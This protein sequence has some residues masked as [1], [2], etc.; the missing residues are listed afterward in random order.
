MLFKVFAVDPSINKMGWAV[1]NSREEIINAGILN[2]TG[3]GS[4]NARIKMIIHEIHKLLVANEIK[5][6]DYFVVEACAQIVNPRS[7]LILE[8]VRSAIETVAIIHGVKVPGRVNPR[9]IHVRMLG[10]E[11]PEK[12]SKIKQITRQFVSSNYLDFFRVNNIDVDRKNQDIFDAILIGMY[13]CRVM[14]FARDD[15]EISKILSDI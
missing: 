14:I 15:Y 2:Y 10:L 6:S 9:S 8:R 3:R 7:F 1:L 13:F 5:N 11:K 4:V 12:R